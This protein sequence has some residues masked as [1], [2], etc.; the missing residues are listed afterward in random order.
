MSEKIYTV[1]EF[2]RSMKNYL[3]MGD[4]TNIFI[5]G[6]MSNITYYKSG[7]LYFNLKDEKSQIKCSCFG[8]KVKKVP[9]DLKEGDSV[10]IFGDIN[11]YE[12]R[13]EISISARHIEKKNKIGDM[14]ARLEELKNRMKK[15]GYF[16]EYHKK[17]LP[18]YP[19]NIGVVTAITGAAIHDIIATAKK[20]DKNVNIYIYSAKVQGDGAA[21]DIVKGIEV[22]NKMPE[23]DMIIAGRGGGSIEDLWAFNEESVAMAFFN[24][25]KPIISAVGHES[26]NLLSDLVAD[27][28]AATPTQA[29]ELSVPEKNI[30]L[31][32]LDEKERYL[33]NSLLRL[34]EN[35]KTILNS[36]I[37]AYPLIHFDKILEKSQDTINILYAK[38]N[39]VIEDRL[40]DTNQMVA[41]YV[42]KLIGL[43]PLAILTRGYATVSYNDTIVKDSRD[44]KVGEQVFVR[45]S[46]GNF[47]ATV[48]EIERK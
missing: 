21:D 7:H 20:R 26:D 45:L 46:Q 28:R 10:K 39:N 9:T 38:L 35:K 4:Y 43:N 1:S 18:K 36:R 47:M 29:I 23:I 30:L 14:F 48:D 2:N 5:E 11:F 34:V 8:Y 41:I 33:K 32:E 15:Q 17:P 13:G 6:E 12:V 3:A 40:K 25:Q 42:Q 16:E 37:N 31:R 27:K 22:L 24:S 19:K 44:L